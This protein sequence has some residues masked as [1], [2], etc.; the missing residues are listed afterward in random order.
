MV[1]GSSEG[2]SGRIYPT[3][4]EQIPKGLPV[5]LVVQQQFYRLL[6]AV[7]ACLNSLHGLSVSMFAL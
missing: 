7:D 2:E 5:L 1:Y 4:I 3:D 6:S